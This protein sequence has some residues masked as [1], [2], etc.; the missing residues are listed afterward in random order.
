M[1]HMGHYMANQGHF[2]ALQNGSRFLNETF[3][4][5]MAETSPGTKVPVLYYSSIPAVFED[6][7]LAHH[8]ITS[9]VQA[10]GMTYGPEKIH[11]SGA[12]NTGSAG[13]PNRIGRFMGVVVIT[14]RVELQDQKNPKRRTPVSVMELR[15][16]YPQEFEIL[17]PSL[18]DE[19]RAMA[20]KAN[21]KLGGALAHMIEGI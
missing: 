12:N 3:I 19:V 6:K 17:E 20:V 1:E 15:V 7:A 18:D 9:N 13:E 5:S 11:L 4:N 8:L 14:D 21:D 2:F 10:V 16:R